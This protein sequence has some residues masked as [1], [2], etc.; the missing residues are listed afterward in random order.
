VFFVLTAI[1][2]CQ[3]FNSLAQTLFPIKLKS[4]ARDSLV[5]AGGR[6]NH[7][8]SAKTTVTISVSLTLI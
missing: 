7:A 4:G 6:L 8:Q 2:V 1:A 3:L 5:M